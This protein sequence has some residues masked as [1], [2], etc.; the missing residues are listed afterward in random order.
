MPKVKIDH[1][2]ADSYVFLWYQRE[3]IIG[4]KKQAVS[5]AAGNGGNHI[6]LIP[7]EHVVIVITA[8]AYNTMEGSMQGI[9]MVED[10][11]NKAINTI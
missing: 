2:L 8:T 6:F 7:K 9:E 4:D 1:E 10:Y 11:I 5:F 3:M